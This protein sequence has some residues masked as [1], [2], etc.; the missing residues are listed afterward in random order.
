MP[1]HS[2]IARPLVSRSPEGFELAPGTRQALIVVN[3]VFALL[4][5]VALLLFARLIVISTLIGIGLGAILAPQLRWV[6]R[7]YQVPRAV[8]AAIVA[9]LGLAVVGIVGYFLFGLV[10]A[11]F[12]ALSERMPQLIESLQAL[13]NRWAARYPGLMD[14]AASIDVAGTVRAIGANLF[15]GA[16]S[17]FSIAGGL[18]FAFVV[19][20]YTAIDADRYHRGLLEA[21]PPRA[22]QQ[23][24]AFLEASAL[25][26]RTW[27]RAQLLDMAIIG[28]LTSLGLLAVGADY[29]LLFGVLTA[30]L[31]IIPYAGI[32]IVVAFASLVTLASDA[33]RLPWVIGVFVL[34]QQLEGH[35][36][37]PMVMRGAAQ[38]P[39][40]PLLVFMLLLGTWGGLLGVLMAPP[41]FAVLL[42]AWRGWYVP[43][44]QAGQ[45][46]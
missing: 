33:S 34:T 38:L 31:G 28:T 13:T 23:L 27:F 9:A 29:W 4:L 1:R 45:L 7:R 36:I 14:G 2:N 39:A 3:Y 41:L 35:V 22:R 18:V 26:I 17:G 11:Q 30:L 32:A 25:T 16:W 44:V 5:L 8:S 40:V 19:A 15:R 20:L 12:V 42:V 24:A 10:Q 6:L 46:G 43:R 21:C 37:L